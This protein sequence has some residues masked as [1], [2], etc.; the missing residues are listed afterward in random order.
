L[1]GTPH[2]LVVDDDPDVRDLVEIVLSGGGYAVTTARDGAAALDLLRRTKA[3]LILLD[4]R[5][6]IMDGWEFARVYRQQPG[7]HAPIVAFTAARDAALRADEIQADGYLA[8]P[9]DVAELLE[10]VARHTGQA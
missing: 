2:V 6:P 5:M 8:K 4:M 10:L 7:P 3:D 9:F 1:S